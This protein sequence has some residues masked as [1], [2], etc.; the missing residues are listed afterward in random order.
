MMVTLN[1]PLSERPR[2]ER[3]YS[4]PTE[5]KKKKNSTVEKHNFDFLAKQEAT[6]APFKMLGGESVMIP[7]TAI[8]G[9]TFYYTARV[10][11]LAPSRVV[12]LPEETALAKMK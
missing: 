7:D 5:K 6:R 11:G 9:C 8:I 12:A 4:Q 10:T 3:K 1:V 2:P